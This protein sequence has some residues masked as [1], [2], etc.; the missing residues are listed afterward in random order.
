M[1]FLVSV[2]RGSKFYQADSPIA[3]R[4][5]VSDTTD[6]VVVGCGTGTGSGPGSY[7]F[8]MRKGNEVFTV[9]DLESGLSP[10]QL[11]A[12]FVAL[13]EEFGAVQLASVPRP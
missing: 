1:W 9:R 6:M 10:A 12:R 11:L 13:S 2:V 8:E 7:R 5:L 3:N 4:M